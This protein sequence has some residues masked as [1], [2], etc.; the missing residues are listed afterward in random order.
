MLRTMAVKV[1]RLKRVNMMT[2]LKTLWS[3]QRPLLGGVSSQYQPA[4]QSNHAPPFPLQPLQ[5]SMVAEPE[6]ELEPME[7]TFFSFRA[8]MI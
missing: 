5:D 4:F 8:L 6:Q 3:T 2:R 1:K 7:G